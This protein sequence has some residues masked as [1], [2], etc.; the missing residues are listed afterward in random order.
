MNVNKTFDTKILSQQVMRPDATAAD[1]VSYELSETKNKSPN[2]A[3]VELSSPCYQSSQC[4]ISL[5]FL[6]LFTK[7]FFR[8]STYIILQQLS[9]FHTCSYY[10]FNTRFVILSNRYSILFSTPLLWQVTFQAPY[11]L[12]VPDTY[13]IRQYGHNTQSRRTWIISARYAITIGLSFISNIFALFFISFNDLWLP[14]GLLRLYNFRLY[15]LNS[16][17]FHTRCVS[18]TGGTLY[19]FCSPQ[20]TYYYFDYIAL[21]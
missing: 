5:T 20:S 19:L 4:S 13:T 2:K 21:W 7:L 16:L 10:N 15:L 12:Y 3:K 11:D 6:K 14:I 18:R 1:I 9:I 17:S 8:Q